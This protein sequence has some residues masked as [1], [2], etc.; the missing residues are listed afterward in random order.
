MTT[1]SWGK[2]LAML[3]VVVLLAVAMWSVDS[4]RNSSPSSV[5]ERSVAPNA[6]APLEPAAE[7]FADAAE[8][9]STRAPIAEIEPPPPELVVTVVDGFSLAP[10]AAAT[11]FVEREDLDPVERE[12]TQEHYGSDAEKV[13]ERLGAKFVC[14]ASGVVRVP[15]PKG[16]VV[17]WAQS[18]VN[19]GGNL[20]EP[21]DEQVSIELYEHFL[22]HVEIVDGRGQPASGVDVRLFEP[23]LDEWDDVYS[24]TTD[25]HGRAVFAVVRPDASDE[26]VSFRLA[27]PFVACEPEL[28]EFASSSPP[29]DVLRLTIGDTGTVELSVTSSVGQRVEV[30]ARLDLSVDAESGEALAFGLVNGGTRFTPTVA[31]HA[32][33]ERIGLGLRLEVYARLDGYWFSRR[34]IAGPSEAGESISSAVPIEQI[35]SLMRGRIVDPDGKPL[36]QRQLQGRTLWRFGDGSSGEVNVLRAG[37]SDDDGR[38]EE[39]MADFHSGQIGPTIEILARRFG[40]SSATG[41]VSVPRPIQEGV[42]IARDVYEFGEIV[43]TVQSTFVCGRVFDEHGVANVQVS[44]ELF[45]LDTDGAQ[46]LRGVEYVGGGGAFEFR[47]PDCPESL[48]VRATSQSHAPGEPQT[49]TRGQTDVALRLG[50]RIECGEF[51]GK[52]LLP[53]GA[54]GEELHLR[55]TRTSDGSSRGGYEL[56]S[57]GEFLADCLVPGIYELRVQLHGQQLASVERIEVAPGKATTLEPIDLRGKVHAIA[58]RVR[59]AAGAPVR[60]ATIRAL[61]VDSEVSTVETDQSG[62]ATLTSLSAS[63]DLL[64]SAA[65]FRPRVLRRATS[66]IDVVLEAG[67]EVQVRRPELGEAARDFELQLALRY[68]GPELAGVPLDDFAV[69]L[70]SEAPALVRL[71]FAGRYELVEAKWVHH[72]SG[73]E[74]QVALADEP[75]HAVADETL[76]IEWPTAAL[77]EALARAR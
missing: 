68:V 36:A 21:G 66:G 23:S 18:G 27:T 8:S 9:S 37:E 1:R 2:I 4:T 30:P 24:T 31:G 71:P 63:H 39:L 14:D 22:V 64:V 7:G 77:L 12:L 72:I 15:R 17:I 20:F 76:T 54:D 59:D 55:V 48:M 60:A 45:E 44:V 46:R 58:V 42:P 56:T 69:V 38:F 49:V 25:E 26:P 10:V 13:A 70:S 47:C 53:E 75:L 3:A 41:S 73:V 57:S 50:E 74:W 40:G 29:S 34:T 62:L 6:S 52:F 16:S 67:L 28:H 35:R 5:E 32:R 43:L 11:V 51:R 19:Y 65:G 61:E 33:F